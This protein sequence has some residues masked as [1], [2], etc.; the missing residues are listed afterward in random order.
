MEPPAGGM[1]MFQITLDR[2]RSRSPGGSKDESLTRQLYR[3]F[4]RRIAEGSLGAGEKIPSSRRLS[5]ELGVARNVV[6]DAYGQLLSEGYLEARAGSGT[7][8]ADGASFRA[9]PGAADRA[10]GPRQTPLPQPASDPPDLIDFRTGVPY[11]SG[12]PFRELTAAFRTIFRDEPPG[13]FGYGDPAGD[14]FFRTAVANYLRRARDIECRPEEII[15][16]VGAAEALSLCAI[17]LGRSRKTVIVEDPVHLHF[18]QTLKTAGMR[19]LPVSV[20]EQGLLPGELPP[21]GANAAFVFVT[22]SH[23]FPFGGVLPIQRRVDLARYAAVSGC[24]IV[25]DD[26]E[27]EFRFEGSPVSSLRELCPERAVYIGSFSKTLSPAFRTGYAVVP[28]DLAAD[29]REAKYALNNHTSGCD[30]MVLSKLLESGALERHIA[31]MKKRYRKHRTALLAA[32]DEYFPG[33][34]G[35]VNA[36]AG[37]HAVVRFPGSLFDADALSA[38]ESGGVRVYPVEAHAIRTGR[39]RDHIILGYGNLTADRIRAGIGRLRAVLEKC[40]R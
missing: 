2:S 20:D 37:L 19:L 4:R 23:Q 16:T 11:L 10:S 3:Q 1:T 36:S 31:D 33:S 15:V 29:F 6:L 5:E 25:E 7:Y 9:G 38:L 40:C 26:Y 30:Q 32:L 14:P 8:V 24:F 39:Y 18:Q 35:V 21:P 34:H 12:L 28:P 13:A 22:P 17:V 27:S